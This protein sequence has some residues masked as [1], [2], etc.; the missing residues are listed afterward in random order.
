MLTEVGFVQNILGYYKNQVEQQVMIVKR[1]IK[2]GNLL[3]QYKYILH[4]MKTAVAIW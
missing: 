1:N 3:Q 4:F 2:K